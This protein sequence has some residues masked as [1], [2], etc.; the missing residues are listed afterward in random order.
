MYLRDRIAIPE[1]CDPQVAELIR[2]LLDSNANSRR[3]NTR[4]SAERLM[5]L[6]IFNGT[7]WTKLMPKEWLSDSELDHEQLI[8]PVLKKLVKSS[9]LFL[10]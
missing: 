1:G 6:G 8:E 10:W 4:A 2:V 7:D 9:L 5:S 3:F